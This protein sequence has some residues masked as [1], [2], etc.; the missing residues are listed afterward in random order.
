MGR[1][2]YGTVGGRRSGSAAWQWIIIGGTLGFGCA[3]IFVLTLLT[4]GALELG[5]ADDDT[6]ASAITPPPTPNVQATVDAAMAGSV[7]QADVQATVSAALAVG[8]D[9]ALAATQTAVPTSTSV[10]APPTPTPPVLETPATADETEAV[11]PPAETSAGTSDETGGTDAGSLLEG[12]GADT[13]DATGEQAAAQQAT[14]I[15]P[16]FDR[17]QALRSPTVRVEGGTFTMGTD[18]IEIRAAVDECVQRDGGDCQVSY[19]ADS[20][21]AHQVTIDTFWMEQTE[22]T[23]A[24]YV[25][26]LD[27]LGPGSHRNACGGFLCVQTTAENEF[28]LITFDSQNYDIGELQ[29]NFPVVGVT[30][31]GAQEYCETLGGRL[32]TEAEWERAARGDDGRIY[33][34]GNT[35]V[36]EYARTSRPERVNVPLEVGSVGVNASPYGVLDMA[37]NVSEWVSDW[38]SATYYNQPAASDPNPQ[39][40]SSGSDKVVR[41]GSWDTV[42]FFT[43]AVHRQHFRPDDPSLDRGFRCAFDS[44]PFGV[45]NGTTP[46]TGETNLTDPASLGSG[47]AGDETGSEAVTEEPVDA[48][49]QLPS[50]PTDR[51]NVTATPAPAVPPGG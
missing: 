12:S 51:P 16:R 7:A 9:Q 42:P 6:V 47:A 21:P 45:T 39:G 43:R 41:G 8:V 31:Y 2:N 36:M 17:L 50:V 15:D 48:R 14:T 11:Q 28:S 1:S 4:L 3:A 13:A 29:Q 40:P 5:G 38:F 32:P 44:D 23:N 33:P 20:V 46:D 35:W 34:W 30:W 25:A 26:F 22:V 49:P 18:Q 24:Q 19:G 27:A 37:G 10:V